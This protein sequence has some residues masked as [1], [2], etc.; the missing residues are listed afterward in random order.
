V[1]KIAERALNELMMIRM[2]GSVV[3]A[4]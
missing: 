3:I 2:I 1:P 4:L